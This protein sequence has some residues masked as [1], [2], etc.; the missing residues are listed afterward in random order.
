MDISQVRN[1]NVPLET[2]LNVHSHSAE[3][4]LDRRVFDLVSERF[5]Q[6]PIV[7]GSSLKSSIDQKLLSGDEA[8][9]SELLNHTTGESCSVNGGD[10]KVSTGSLQ[11]NGA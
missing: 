6:R 7:I 11:V 8:R 5:T 1:R 9:S 10:E 3:A 4:H 2:V